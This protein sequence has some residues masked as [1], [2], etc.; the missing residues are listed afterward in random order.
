MSTTTTTTPDYG[1][2]PVPAAEAK[3][4]DFGSP[5]LKPEDHTEAHEVY[6]DRDFGFATRK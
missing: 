3:L 4:Q 5:D 1:H 6:Q 2:A